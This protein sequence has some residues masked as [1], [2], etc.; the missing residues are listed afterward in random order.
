MTILSVLSMPASVNACSKA[1]FCESVSTV[2]PDFEETTTAVCSIFCSRASRTWSGLVESRTTSS[3]PAVL[4]I[5]SGASEEPPMPQSTNR[6][7]PF[8]ANSDFKA[9][10][11]AISGVLSVAEL[12]QPRRIEDSASA[13][14]PQRVKSFAPMR[15]ATRSSMRAGKNSATAA[16]TDPPVTTFSC[17]IDNLL[18]CLEG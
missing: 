3:T 15:L 10:I 17:D 9:K 11:G 1:R 2:E 8:A 14:F 5:T 6:L 18:C 16:E 12:T 13:S 7:I 4:V